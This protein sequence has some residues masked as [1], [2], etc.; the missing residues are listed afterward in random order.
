[1]V[2]DNKIPIEPLENLLKAFRQDVVR[3]RYDDFN[4][5]LDYCVNSANPVGRLVLM[6]F[7]CHDEEFFKYSDKIC[8]ALQLTNFWQDVQIDLQKNRVYLPEEDL[9]KFGYSYEELFDK[10]YNDSFKSLMGF[11]VERTQKL[12]DEGKKLIELTAQTSGLKKLSKELKLTWLG[13]SKILEKIREI[14]YDVFT[15]RPKIG[16]TDKLTI[17]LSSRF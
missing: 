12:F 5:I 1:T 6:I 3:C 8:T 2:D 7:G 11:E 13:G 16:F 4:E 14:E 9:M 15:K 10:K 17:F